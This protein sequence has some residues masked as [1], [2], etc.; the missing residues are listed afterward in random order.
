MLKIEDYK[1]VFVVAGLV[2]VL[3]FA[4]PAIGAFVRLPEG[5]KF[6]ELWIL[7]PG[8]VIENYPFNVMVGESYT[9][10]VGVGN[11]MGASAYYLLC[12]KLRNQTEPLPNSTAGTPSP[13]LPLFAYSVFVEDGKTWE[14]PLTFSL[15]SVSFEGN[16]CLIH[17]LTINGVAFDV[18][19]SVL[20]D[21]ENNGYFYQL[22]IELWIYNASSRDFYFHN[23]FVY[24]W[25][26]VTVAV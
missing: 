24:F 14:Q 7:G 22:L 15:N 10:Y 16:R 11:H 20:W 5:E 3:F 21:S 4:S 2:G 25:L 18:G 9:V 19:K 17:N 8:H 23:R 6:S 26:N 12:F 1:S 13:L